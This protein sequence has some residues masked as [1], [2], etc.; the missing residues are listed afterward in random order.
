MRSRVETRGNSIGEYFLWVELK[1][2]FEL[3]VG[4]GEDNVKGLEAVLGEVD[5]AG[6]GINREDIVGVV[7]EELMSGLSWETSPTCF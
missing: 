4:G 3:W 6:F 1:K 7:E 2:V 5:V